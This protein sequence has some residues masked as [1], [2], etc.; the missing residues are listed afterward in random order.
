MF[1]LSF[2][3]QTFGVSFSKCSSWEFPIESRLPRVV[4][5]HGIVSA[6]SCAVFGGVLPGAG[7]CFIVVGGVEFCFEFFA[8]ATVKAKG[9]K[10]KSAVG[11]PNSPRQ[12]K[13]FVRNGA[14][15]SLQ[16]NFLI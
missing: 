11:I 4:V 9:E 14:K 7:D 5:N 3:F 16:L 13:I 12:G 8:R 15:S 10:R 2:R 1:V 6:I